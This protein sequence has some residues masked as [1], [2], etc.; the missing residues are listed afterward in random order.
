M[1]VGAGLGAVLLALAVGGALLEQ[2][3]LPV[4][5]LG[6]LLV[7]VLLVAIDTDRRVRALRA[8]VREQV[9]TIDMSGG[10]GAPAPED[11]VGTVRVLQEQY[12]GRLDRLQDTIEE[13][14]RRRES[15]R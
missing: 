14:V 11:I 12:T 15:D 3:W 13:A 1:L 5:T 7:L 8:Y 4:L 10:R 6:T 2:W 9:A